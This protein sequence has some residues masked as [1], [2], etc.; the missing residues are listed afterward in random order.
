MKVNKKDKEKKTKTTSQAK[1]TSQK[2]GKRTQGG[3]SASSTKTKT[4]SKSTS[5]PKK[6][7]N[8]KPSEKKTTAKSNELILMKTGLDEQGNQK[9]TEIKVYKRKPAGWKETN[10]ATT[11]PRGYKWIDNGKSRFGGK[12]RSALLKTEQ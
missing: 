8:V 4:T 5:K 10:G 12:R 2:S 1:T 9:Y 3:K 6:G 7:N 11:A